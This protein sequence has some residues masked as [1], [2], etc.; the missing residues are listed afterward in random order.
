MNREPLFFVSVFFVKIGL[1]AVGAEK[2]G[3]L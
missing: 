1:I 3:R 2:Y